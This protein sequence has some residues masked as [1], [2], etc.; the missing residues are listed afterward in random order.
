MSKLESMGWGKDG[1]EQTED[2]IPQEEQIAP[3]LLPV[4]AGLEPKEMKAIYNEQK[5]KYPRLEVLPMIIKG[6]TPKHTRFYVVRALA[7]SE[8]PK[9]Q[10]LFA[11]LQDKEV[12]IFRSKLRDEFLADLNKNAKDPI[13]EIP[14]DRVAE[15]ELLANTQWFDEEHLTTILNIIN[16]IGMNM[17]AVCYPPNHRERVQADLVPPGD[18][19]ILAKGASSLS[20]WSQV[21]TDIAVYERENPQSDPAVKALYD[22]ILGDEPGSEE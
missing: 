3:E 10:E 19:D 13:K 11:R 2:V 9:L 22:S 16:Q 12:E 20:G 8:V 14:E 21:R 17:M 6:I 15:F 18:V 5:A 7:Q 4:N 1:S